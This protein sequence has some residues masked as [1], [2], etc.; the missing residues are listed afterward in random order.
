M[1]RDFLTC[2]SCSGLR[3]IISNRLLSIAVFCSHFYIF[4]RVLFRLVLSTI[5]FEVH[6]RKAVPLRILMFFGFFS[7]LL[8]DFP[9]SFCLLVCLF[10]CL[11]GVF[12]AHSHSRDSSVLYKNWEI[13]NN[14][15]EFLRPKKTIEILWNPKKVA[16][17]NFQHRKIKFGC[18]VEF[19][20]NH[21]A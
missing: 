10:V 17:K 2:Y 13:Q 8:S 3:I 5:T 16:K 18:M 21:F 1:I 9:G 7:Y 15:S 20:Q 12:F 14:S 11:F 6:L 4:L 19:M